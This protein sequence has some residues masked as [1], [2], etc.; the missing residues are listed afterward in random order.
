MVAVFAVPDSRH[1][2]RCRVRVVAGVADAAGAR[3][4]LSRRRLVTARRG[5]PRACTLFASTPDHGCLTLD[6]S[7]MQ[8]VGVDRVLPA[9]WRRAAEAARPHAAWLRGNGRA[10]LHERRC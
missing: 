1:C 2:I 8:N 4:W 6:L 7:V 9:L 5:A 3:A 10:R